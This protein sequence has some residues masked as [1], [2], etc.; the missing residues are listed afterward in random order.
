MND[1]HM[2]IG[3]GFPIL[4]KRQLGRRAVLV[5]LV[6]PSHVGAGGGG[7]LARERRVAR[8]WLLS[9]PARAAGGFAPR[10]WQLGSDRPGAGAAGGPGR[11]PRVCVCGGRARRGVRGH[12]GGVAN[13]GGRKAPCPG[14]GVRR[15]PELTPP[16]TAAPPCANAAK[17]TQPLGPG[18]PAPRDHRAL[19]TPARTVAAERD[20]L[21][22][23]AR[24]QRDAAVT[25]TGPPT[26]VVISGKWVPRGKRVASLP[27]PQGVV[28]RPCR[29]EH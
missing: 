23:P 21:M 12:L 29:P 24:C 26:V 13:G 1:S 11:G 5:F 22:P 20:S 19:Q 27:P 9:A 8:R 10:G 28:D 2:K 4:S 16:P 3:R 15:H 17:P 7:G 25:A 14:R 6:S 18:Q